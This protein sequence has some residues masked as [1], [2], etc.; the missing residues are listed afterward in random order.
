MTPTPEQVAAAR[1]SDGTG[2]RCSRA[3]SGQQECAT[4]NKQKAALEWLDRYI[5]FKEHPEGVPVGVN[6]EVLRTI[7]ALVRPPLPQEPALR[8]AICKVRDWSLNED[9]ACMERFFGAHEL[10]LICKAAE[11]PRVPAVNDHRAID[12]AVERL[13][14]AGFP[15]VPRNLVAALLRIM[16]EPK[17]TATKEVEIE[18]WGV[19][20]YGGMVTFVHSNQSVAQGVADAWNKCPGHQGAY[21]VVRLTGK[22]TVKA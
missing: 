11:A 15:A 6:A 12:A 7:R 1:E 5:Q 10:A 20:A 4:T 8:D 16:H 9:G 13:W 14:E 17:K 19:S 22:A 18:M 2:S 3:D 21:T